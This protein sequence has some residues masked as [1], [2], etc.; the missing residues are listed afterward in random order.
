MSAWEAFLRLSGP[1]GDGL[2]FEAWDGIWSMIAVDPTRTLE[3]RF[4]PAQGPRHAFRPHRQWEDMR[5]LL[6]PVD[7]GPLRDWPSDL[8]PPPR[9]RGGLAGTLGYGAR[10]AIEHL[11]DRHQRMDD[12][13]HARL[14]RF[15]LVLGH[16]GPTGRLFAFGRTEHGADWEERL[17][18]PAPAPIAAVVEGPVVRMSDRE[19]AAMATRVREAIGRGEVFQA[20]VARSWTARVEGDAL[21]FYPRI[22]AINP[23]PW[24]CVHR[25]PDWTVLSNS[26]E[27]LLRIREGRAETRPIAG[28]HPRGDGQ[29][30]QILRQQLSGSLKE[31]AEHLMLLD[32]ARNDLGRFCRIGTVEVP[33]IMGIEA[34]SHVWHIVSTVEGRIDEGKDAVDALRA[35]FPCGTI[36]GAPRIRCM[37][38]IDEL[39][40]LAR[41]FYTGSTGWISDTGDAEWNVLIRSATARAGRLDFHAGAGI[42]WDSDPEREAGETIHKARA[43]LSALE[44]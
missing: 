26:P 42:V 24:G 18:R 33:R 38:L 11:P 22:R 21:A 13:P 27:L 41:G 10:L 29:A 2:F 19:Y 31:K 8:G 4:P 5:D 30:D 9:F 1:E 3:W 16:H 39:E 6:Q 35:M 23:S 40:P 32:L 17:S 44:P 37:E 28:T 34:Y 36:T 7:D 15:P 14:S 43:W 20:N 25:T 12:P